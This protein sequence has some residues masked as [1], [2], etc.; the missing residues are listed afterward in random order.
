M[1]L[2]AYP[3]GIPCWIEL[4]ALD[5]VRAAGFYSLLFGWRI[6]EP[7]D[8]EERR[9]AL[10]HEATEWRVAYLRGKPV[11]AV[12]PKYLPGRPGWLTY[13]S[14]ENADATAASVKQVGGQVISE[15]S[16]IADAGRAAVF[17]DPAGAVFG[18]WQPG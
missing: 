13:V 4:K 14:V 1:E 2:S 10:M 16:D 15:P 5:P 17:T 9:T 6:D 3:P 8:Q 18:V 12:T 7:E 11:A